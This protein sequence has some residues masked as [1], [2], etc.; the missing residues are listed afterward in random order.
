MMLVASAIG[1]GSMA[2]GQPQTKAEIPFAFRAGTATTP[3][4]HLPVS[5]HDEFAFVVSLF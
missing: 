1:L 5:R 2:H 3:S 4:A